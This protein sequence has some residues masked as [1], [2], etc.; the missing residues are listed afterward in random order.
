MQTMYP[1][2]PNSPQTSLT[3]DITAM[4]TTIEVADGSKLPDA[5][6]LATIGDLDDENAETILYTQKN[7]NVLSGITRGF[8]GQAKAWP[9]GT[10]I[11]RYFTAYDYHAVKQNIEE[12]VLNNDIHITPDER[13]DWN[14]KETPQGAQQKADQ[15]ETNAKVYTDT[16]FNQLNQEINAHMADNA[17]HKTSDV[18]R[19]ET[20]TPIKVEV[21]SSSESETPEQ[22]RI[23]FDASQ[24]KFF[25]GNGSEWL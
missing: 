17:I 16:V 6:N 8:Q 23:I 12:H 24:G 15:A 3:Q 20:I 13:S 21:V 1:A 2:I 5:P 9:A 25:G 7:G 18:I 4:Q 10:L 14:A 19:T 22:G 11:A